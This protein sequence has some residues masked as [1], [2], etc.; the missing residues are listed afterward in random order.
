M[1]DVIATGMAKDPDERYATTVELA[2]AAREA[3]TTPISRPEPSPAPVPATEPAPVPTAPPTIAAQHQTP[4]PDNVYASALT[5]QR[6]PVEVP[7]HR[8]EPSAERPPPT[9]PSW[10]WWRR[11]AVLISAAFI[12]TVVAIALALIL[13]TTGN[14]PASRTSQTVLPDAATL[15][16][17]SAQTTRELK[18][19]HLE[20]TIAGTIKDWP[21]K[22]LSGDLINS[23]AV[24]EKGHTRLTLARLGND[25]EADFV[26]LDGTLYM[27]LK[28]GVWNNFGA[29]SDIFDP[30]VILKPDTGLANILSN[31]SDPTVVGLETINGVRTVKITGQ[32]SADAANKI[33]PKIAASGPVPG[34]AWIRADDNHELV[35]VTLE[36]SP[37]NSIETT[38]SKWND[39]VSV[40]KPPG[41]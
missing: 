20:Q 6:P 10:P 28:P 17:Q 27:S 23:P 25:A 12:V 21:I 11:K 22:T 32:V 40:E 19:A 36:P 3:I 4:P 39:P 1:D 16:N 38:L 33:A 30:T 18:S 9:P 24:A 34:T 14:H 41:V 26:V 35:Q 7:T 8:P 15:V 13:V 37:G 5:R 31:F 29:A 2:D